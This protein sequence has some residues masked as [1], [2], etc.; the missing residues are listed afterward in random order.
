MRIPNNFLTKTRYSLLVAVSLTAAPARSQQNIG[1]VAENIAGQGAQVANMI[2]VGVFIVGLVVG[3][4]TI[5]KLVQN[6]KN[7]NDPSNS[8]GNIVKMG[9]AAA[10]LMALPETLGVG[11]TSLFG[12]GAETVSAT[13]GENALSID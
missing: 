3:A 10:A 9:L 13:T 11:V 1:Q 4:V 8:M 6:G 12:S 5:N 2:G 7:P